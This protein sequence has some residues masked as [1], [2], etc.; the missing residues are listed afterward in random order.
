MF[1]HDN[2]KRNIKIYVGFSGCAGGQMDRDGTEPAGKHTFSM[3]RG[4]RNIN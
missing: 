4:M 1:A 2:C 3:E